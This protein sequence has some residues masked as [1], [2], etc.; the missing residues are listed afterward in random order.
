MDR[1]NAIL[2]HPSY[3]MT[4]DRVAELE[5]DRIFCG[6]SMDHL[7]DVA[8]IAYILW[9]ESGGQTGSGADKEIIYAAALLHDAGRAKQYEDR[10]PHELE[11]ARIAGEILP[12]C[13]FSQTETKMII[14][15]ILSHRT[16]SPGRPGIS[17]IL[18]QADKLSRRC[19]CCL[20]SEQCDW[21]TK[22]TGLVY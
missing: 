22:N 3:I 20:A 5:K 8:R 19:D 18:Y 11:S 15:A 21:A 4:I 9:L 17:G 1:V 16:E 6:H 12:E 14:D 2:R 7:L 13:G 10:T